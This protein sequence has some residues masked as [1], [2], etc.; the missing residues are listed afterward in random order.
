[1]LQML[2]GFD[3]ERREG[4]K[5]T[6]ES[7]SEDHSYLW[8]NGAMLHSRGTGDHAQQEA[9]DD[10]DQKRAARDMIRDRIC[11]DGDDVACYGACCAR[12]TKQKKQR[13]FTYHFIRPLLDL[14]QYRQEPDFPFLFQGP[15]FRVPFS[16]SR[17]PCTVFGVPFSSTTCT[18]HRFILSNWLA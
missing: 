10:I 2:E 9:P 4:C 15:A 16:V 14:L 12:Q 5:G 6:Q 3:A 17:F 7:C 13:N 11:P 18:T 8:R 1:M